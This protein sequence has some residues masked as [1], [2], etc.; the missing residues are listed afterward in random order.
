MEYRTFS[1]VYLKR[2]LALL[3][4]CFPENA[5][6]EQ[7]F[8]WKHFDEFF[9]DASVAMV[10]LDGDAVCA[11]VCFSPVSIV[12]GTRHCGSV[13]RCAV[14]ATHPNFRRRGIVRDLTL[15]IEEHLGP[16]TRYIGFSNESGV[17]IDRHS[18]SIQYQIVGQIV[19]RYV[20][21][22]P[23]VSPLIIKASDTIPILSQGDSAYFQLLKDSRYT[24]WRYRRNP[25]YNYSYFSVLNRSGVV[26]CIVCKERPFLLE[27]VDLLLPKDDPVLYFDTI[28]AFSAY[29]FRR[30][31]FLISYSYLP[32]AF[33]SRSFP[34]MSLMKKIGYYLTV[35]ASDK[36][37]C[38]PERWIIQAGDIQ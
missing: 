33:W 15:K 2:V 35:K 6:Q 38:D 11:F 13:Y 16:D 21:S 29:A 4:I 9:R 19:T 36:D 27:V 10:A 1:A 5:I 8:L 18:K 31:K 28:R 32:N 14:Q 22:F 25:K 34:A 7:S 37:L 17:K 26:G 3:Q 23:Y 24:D 30:M 20:L 12:Q